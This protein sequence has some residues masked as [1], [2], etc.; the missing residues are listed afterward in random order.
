MS[1]IGRRLIIKSEVLRKRIKLNKQRC[2]YNLPPNTLLVNSR[3][4]NNMTLLYLY[5]LN[6]RKNKYKLFSYYFF[7]KTN[8]IAREGN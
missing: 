1:K 5:N 7:I 3:N 8:Y 4:L 6:G 2:L